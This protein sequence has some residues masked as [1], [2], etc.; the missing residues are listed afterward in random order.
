MI[1]ARGGSKSVPRKNLAPVAGRPLIGWTI[2]SALASGALTRT[3]VSTDDDEIA[4]YARECGAEVPF[5]RPPELAGDNSPMIGVVRHG[6]QWYRDR[7]DEHDAVVVLQPTSPLR[8]AG[9]I[10]EAVRLFRERDA[11][12]VVSVVPV[13]HRFSPYSVMQEDDGFLQRFW[14]EPTDFDPH[15]RQQQPV[16]WA[17]NGPVVLVSQA[18]RILAGDDLYGDRIV[19]MVMSPED[20][21]DIDEPFDLECAD[22]LLRRRIETEAD[23]LREGG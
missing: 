18:E 7:G 1:P 8:R 19:P 14:T 2:G 9:H 13:P 4:A 21:I 15:I 16:L 6:I 12:S 5:L 22:W 11:D 20:S 10:D 3:V 23:V 17:R